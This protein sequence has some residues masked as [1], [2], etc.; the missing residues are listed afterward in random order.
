MAEKKIN[1]GGMFIATGRRKKSI[2]RVRLCSGKGKIEV[3]DS[4][5][6]KKK[7]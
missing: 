1:K 3:L 4:P 5:A 2:A 7:K 6:S